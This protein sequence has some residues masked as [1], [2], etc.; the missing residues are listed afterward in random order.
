MKLELADC[1]ALNSK[2]VGSSDMRRN[3]I[4]PFGRMENLIGF[5]LS[6]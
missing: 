4:L 1:T 6:G 3:P 2:P 5:L